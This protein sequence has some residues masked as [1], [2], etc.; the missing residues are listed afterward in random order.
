MTPDAL[1]T[2]HARAFARLRPWSAPEFAS[3]LTSPH[4]FLVTLPHAFALGRAVADEAELLTIATDP[5]HQR[6]GMGTACL[7]AFETAA[8]D[9]GAAQ[10]FLEVDSENTAA[11]A[12]YRRF[13]FTSTGRRADYYSLPNGMRADAI[14][15][16]KP[17]T[18]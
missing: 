17:L 7:K 5:A 11:L 15:M 2:L 1:A 18:R 6:S 3:L 9:R 12:L 8:V 14:L 13:G 10:C 16:A 4:V